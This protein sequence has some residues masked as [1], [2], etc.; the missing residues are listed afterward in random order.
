MFWEEFM[1]LIVIFLSVDLLSITLSSKGVL[2]KWFKS[3][4]NGFLCSESWVFCWGDFLGILGDKKNPLVL[5][6][7]VSLI[8]VVPGI[9][10]DLFLGNSF[11]F[12]FFC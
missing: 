6:R 12:M 4:F 2:K 10:L 1:L 11:V 5:L 7:I 8:C 3:L 9:I